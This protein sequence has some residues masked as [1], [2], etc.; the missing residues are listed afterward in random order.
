MV[1]WRKSGFPYE[2][3][4][5]ETINL[6]PEFW[7]QII[8]LYK[9]TRADGFERAISVFWV[10]GELVVT[11][12]VKG[13]RTQVTT[14]ASVSYRYVRT[15]K[16]E[17]LRREILVN[18]K[19]YSKKDV[20]YK[21]V[22]KKLTKPDYLFNMHTHPP[23]ESNGATYYSFFSLQDIKSMLS[24][25]AVITGMI[26]DRLWLLFRTQQ[27]PD[28]VGDMQEVEITKESLQGRL[29][30]GVYSAEFKGKLKLQNTP[31]D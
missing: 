14:N 3:E 19:L 24:S 9:A 27:T 2:Y 30:L 18:N 22:P 25:K 15:H 12:V 10:G 8:K 17:Y 29:H 6:T 26:G 11:S 1:G 28:T 20:Y 23:H 16:P 4:L 31:S 5:P 13:T 7:T 21:K